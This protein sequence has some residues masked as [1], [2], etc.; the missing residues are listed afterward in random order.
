VVES[1]LAGDA[2]AQLVRYRY[3][4][5]SAVACTFIKRGTNDTYLI[6]SG[7]Q[8]AILRAY[9]HGW[10]TRE[11]IEEELEV[12]DH[13]HRSRVR[14]SHALRSR[15]DERIQTIAAPEGERH[16]VLLTHAEGDIGPFD[17]AHLFAL[18]QNL[19]K[20]HEASN[21]FVPFSNR[22]SLDVH[23]LVGKAISLK[24][25]LSPHGGEARR[26][27]LAAR[28][29]AI[30]FLNETA[31]K[32]E[33]QFANLPRTPPHYGL[34]HGDFAG[35]NTHV[36]ANGQQTHFDFDFC[37]FGPRV[38]DLAV[39]LWSRHKIAGREI[40]P[41]QFARFL[42]GYESIRKLSEAESQAIPYF[43][44]CREIFI[45]GVA[46]QSLDRFPR[47]PSE[48]PVTSCVEFVKRWIDENQL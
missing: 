45:M 47:R 38:H 8:R 11:Q 48:D 3:N 9:P 6:S 22:P 33:P 5:N 12:L 19:A 2:L 14:V 25:P 17:E 36:D 13:L 42:E 18:G 30:R 41:Q 21:E 39:M 32:L 37:G 23:H 15:D 40:A 43:V 28:E 34:C 16:L 27:G 44:L 24:L 4:F 1:T 26:E 35:F 20:I 31:Q 7:E 29:F 46:L 10:R